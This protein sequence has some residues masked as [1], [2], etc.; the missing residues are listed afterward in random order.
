MVNCSINLFCCSVLL[1]KSSKDSLSSD[2]QNFG[3]HSAFES[4]STF[5][6]TSVSTESFSLKM[7][8]STSSGVYFL[9]SLHDETVLDK[10]AN[11]NSGIGL[12]DLLDLA[13]VHPNSLTTAFKNFGS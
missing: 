1:Q 6:W 10:F 9:F 11:K 12:T 13:G 3:W 8:A 2:P 7:F 4:S 5:T